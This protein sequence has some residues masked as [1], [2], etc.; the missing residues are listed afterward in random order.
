MNMPSESANTQSSGLLGRPSNYSSLTLPLQE[1]AVLFSQPLTAFKSEPMEHDPNTHTASTESL[2]PIHVEVCQ[3][4]C[5]TLR[6]SQVREM[7]KA[8]L[9]SQPRVLRE[10][11]E[12][13]F[14]DQ[15][16]K[17]HVVSIAVT[18]VP[19]DKV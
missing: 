15:E 5:S 13:E 8:R 17:E 6:R 2:L 14:E 11:V 19:S 12:T 10:M 1:L 9:Q 3:A 4:P 7:V 16:L 18:D